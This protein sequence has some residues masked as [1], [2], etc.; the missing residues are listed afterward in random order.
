MISEG[1][2]ETTES[3]GKPVEAAGIAPLD[4]R[5]A[6]LRAV[7]WI[8]AA[9]MAAQLALEV[10]TAWFVFDV[11]SGKDMMA[12]DFR[13]LL[14]D[15]GVM[16]LVVV[17]VIVFF[18]C[19]VAY[20]RF[21]IRALR[22]LRAAGYSGETVSAPGLILW[23]FVPIAAAFMPARGVSEI[24][25]VTRELTGHPGQRTAP[26]LAAW[27][28]CWLFGGVLSVGAN[29]LARASGIESGSLERV[30]LYYAGSFVSV[31]AG[32]LYIGAAIFFVLLARRIRDAQAEL[33]NAGAADAFS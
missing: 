9:V 11:V 18:V 13:L 33:T 7:F 23:Y 1:S 6:F 21:L 8:Y 32:L 17:S 3:A 19:T 29:F 12:S 27:W 2:V 4:G 28:S 25:H 30:D 31:G 14:A 15:S 16:P 24:W 20:G 26:F 5:F 10:L 22:N